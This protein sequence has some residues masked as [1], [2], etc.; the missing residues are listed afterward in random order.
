MRRQSAVAA[1]LAFAAIGLVGC[2]PVHSD[3]VDAAKTPAPSVSATSSSLAARAASGDDLD[4]VLRSGFAGYNA[5]SFGALLATADTSAPQVQDFPASIE[6]GD[7]ITAVFSCDG[8]GGVDVTVLQGK[9][10]V[11]HYWNEQCSPDVAYGGESAAF[12]TPAEN[13]SL[14]VK[15]DDGVT[16]STVIE[17]PKPKP[18]D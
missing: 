1:A 8:P 15:A 10:S 14:V 6:V 5:D 11:L 3:G 13:L 7:K 18:L 9:E 2:A 17:G 12:K 4:G 16:F